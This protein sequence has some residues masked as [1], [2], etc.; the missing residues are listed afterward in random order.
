MLAITRSRPP[1]RA[2]RCNASKCRLTR[3]REVGPVE[4]QHVPLFE[5]FCT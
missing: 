2:Q 1:Q 4:H 3:A 5:N